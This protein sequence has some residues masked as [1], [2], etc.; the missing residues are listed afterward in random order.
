MS[1]LGRRLRR[2]VP[3]GQSND[4]IPEVV[5]SAGEIP[6]AL[7]DVICGGLMID[8]VVAEDEKTYDRNSLSKWMAYC[9]GGLVGNESNSGNGQQEQP[10]LSPWTREPMGDTVA[11]NRGRN[12]VSA[13]SLEEHRRLQHCKQQSFQSNFPSS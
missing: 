8:P 12:Q 11:P 4:Y 9:R 3:P 2:P 7:A 5:A 13:A 10:V 1:S 6:E